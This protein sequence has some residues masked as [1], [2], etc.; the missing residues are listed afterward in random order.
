MFTTERKKL[1]LMFIQKIY[2][3]LEKENIDRIKYHAQPDS[4]EEVNV[5]KDN[6]S[7]GETNL[8][9]KASFNLSSC[10]Y[11]K[12]SGFMI[13]TFGRFTFIEGY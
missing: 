6:E 9:S 4:D 3:L 2:Q 7:D 10:G 11:K 8:D 13:E 5:H 1:S 12:W